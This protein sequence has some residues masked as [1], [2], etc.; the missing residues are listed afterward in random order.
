MSK[1]EFPERKRSALQCLYEIYTRVS[2]GRKDPIFYS[3]KRHP[4]KYLTEGS[5]KLIACGANDRMNGVEH[6]VS[7]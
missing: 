4:S 3:R 6:R 1:S 5:A 7:F 2:H